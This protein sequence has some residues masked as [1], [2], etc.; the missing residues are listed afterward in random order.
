MSYWWDAQKQR[1]RWGL[2]ITLNGERHRPTKLLPKGWRKTQ[3]EKF[4]RIQSEKYI[5]QVSGV[6]PVTHEIGQAVAAYL[7]DVVPRLASGRNVLQ[8]L[9]KLIDYI[10]GRPFTDLPAVFTEYANDNPGLAPATIRNRLAYLRAA[11]RYAFKHK[12]IGDADSLARLVMPRVNNVRTTRTDDAGVEALLS[13]MDRATA[14]FVTLAYYTAMRPQKE[15]HRLTK[16]SLHRIGGEVWIECGRTKNGEPHMV[17]VHP[18]A[19]WAV[20][21]IPFKRTYRD[22]YDTFKAAAKAIG[23]PELWMYDMRR[24][25]ASGVLNRGGTIDDV[26]VA[27]NQK[28]RAAAERYAHMDLARKKAIFGRISHTTPATVSEL[29]PKKRA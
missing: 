14:A 28:S 8:E 19:E 5:A 11:C 1:W 13:H 26:Q 15:I 21:F 6:E 25:F 10:E 27:L 24:S 18:V 9:A 17:L 22:Y 16:A 29:R 2:D 4:D 20:E 12:R 3:A 7:E 23:R